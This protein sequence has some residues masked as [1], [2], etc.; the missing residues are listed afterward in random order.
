MV[1]VAAGKICGFISG[2][3]D[4][5]PCLSIGYGKLQCP[6]LHLKKD[7]DHRALQSNATYSSRS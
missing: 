3:T 7:G 4:K 5:F 6:L 2:M 1:M